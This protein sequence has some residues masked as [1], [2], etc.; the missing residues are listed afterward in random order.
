MSLRDSL[1]ALLVMACWGFN[2]VAAKTALQTFDPMFLLFLRFA[3]VAA[4][5]V[6]F[7]PI[8]RGKVMGIAI[9]SVLL[10]GL[11]FPLMFIGVRG[12][13]AA[14]AALVVQLQVPFS[15]VLAALIYKDVLGWRRFL[16]MVVAFAGIA[17]IAGAPRMQGNL[18]FIALIVIASFAFAVSNIQ[19]K[20]IGEL[21]GFTLNGWMAL[22]AA[23]QVLILSLLTET[24][25]VRSTVEAPALAWASLA[26]II[27]GSTLAAYGL[28]YRLARIYP[29]NQTMPYLML[30][31]VFGVISGV[32]VLGEPVTLPLLIGGALVIAGVGVIIFRRPRTVNEKATNPT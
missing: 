3:V 8:P 12:V 21:D 14:T 1:L 17:V 22:F 23:P 2:F 28:W 6:P 26:F 24:G 4:L 27:L 16:G 9:L 31:P 13:D 18:H 20:R 15:S 5:V 19:V 30:V 7:V 10:G 29:V 32:V 11:H 25:Q